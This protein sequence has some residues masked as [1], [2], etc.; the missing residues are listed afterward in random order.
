ML[1]WLI[2]LILLVGA[3]L[4]AAHL[5][6]GA[7][8]APGLDLG[9]ERGELRAKVLNFWEDIQYKD[10]DRAAAYHSPEKQATVD[11]PFLIERLFMQKPESLDFMDYEIVFARLDSS[12]LRA[13]VKSRVKVK[14]L[15]KG[16][17]RDQEL[18]LYFH[19]D[20]ESAPWF[21]ELESSLRSTEAEEGKKH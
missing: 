16:D 7:L 5:S 14:N 17:I 21:M 12:G 19:R 9:G 18:I 2:A 8:P 20:N 13:R 10:F 4:A 3:Y 1:K 15:I 11:I 6:G